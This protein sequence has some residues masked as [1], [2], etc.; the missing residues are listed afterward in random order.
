MERLPSSWCVESPDQAKPIL[1]RSRPDAKSE[2]HSQFIAGS[3]DRS[4]LIGDDRASSADHAAPGMIGKTHLATALGY[5]ACQ[6][7]SSVLFANAIDL[8]N[9]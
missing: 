4:A 2:L 7:G 6:H 5:A 1:G 3:A 8:I 9:T